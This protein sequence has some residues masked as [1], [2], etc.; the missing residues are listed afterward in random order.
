MAAQFSATKGCSRARAEVMDRAGKE[1]LAGAAFAEQQHG[2]IGGGHALHHL[3]RFL[4]GGMFA[5]DA[6][7]TVPRGVFLAQQQIFAQEFLLLRGALHQQFQVFEVHWLLDEIER[8]FLH[9]G[10]GFFHRAVRGDQNDGKRGITLACFAQHFQAGIAG[11]FQIRQHQQ[12]SPRANFGDG[13]R[14]SG[15]SSTV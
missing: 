3:A 14:P 10:H 8:A 13:R 6:R 11:K 12:I 5:D 2:G 4:H 1:F 7:K 9:R 15:A